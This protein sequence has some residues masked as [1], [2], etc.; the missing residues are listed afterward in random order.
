MNPATNA[1]LKSAQG[2]S[3]SFNR[4]KFAGHL[5]RY[6]ILTM[7]RVTNT[8]LSLKDVRLSSRSHLNDARDDRSPMEHVFS[9][10]EMSDVYVSV[11]RTFN[12][13]ICIANSQQGLACI[14]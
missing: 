1:L 11:W 10:R 13:A 14:V 7:S 6:L 2:R 3:E 8:T 12:V 4:S 9:H 5:E